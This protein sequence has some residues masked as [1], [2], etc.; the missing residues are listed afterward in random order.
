MLALGLIFIFLTL[1]NGDKNLLYP[2]FSGILKWSSLGPYAANALFFNKP[3]LAAWMVVYAIVY[4]GLIRIRR[5]KRALLLTSVF[6][7][8]YAIICLNFW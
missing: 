2:A 6:G 5:E 1:R 4:A 8:A 7:C 3:F